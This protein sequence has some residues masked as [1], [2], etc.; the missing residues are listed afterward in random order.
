MEI[1]INNMLTKLMVTQCLEDLITQFLKILI[2]LK[3]HENFV[4]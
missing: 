1:L 2:K 4:M 3:N